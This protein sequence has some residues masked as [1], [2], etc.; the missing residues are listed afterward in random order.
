MMSAMNTSEHLRQ[1]WPEYLIEG[2]ALGTFMVAASLATCVLE[3]PGSPLNHLVDGAVARRCLIGIAMG[4]T[5]IALIYSPWGQRSGAHMNPA[6][7][8]TFLR[9][10]KIAPTDAAF[11]IVAQ[12]VGGALGVFFVAALWPAAMASPQVNFIATVPGPWGAT[13][14]FAA[15]LL[16]SMLLIVAVLRVSGSVAYARYTGLCAGALVAIFISVEAPVSGMS[17]NPARTFASTLPSGAWAQYWIYLLAPLL[18]MQIG[19]LAFAGT[20]GS[21]RVCAKLQHSIRRRCIH[22]GYVPTGVS[23]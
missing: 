15:E 16:I 3:Y 7:T 13:A 18:G 10:G 12:F 14:A 2:W 11:Y 1:R 4:L 19:A 8:L 17:I 21:K 22:C 6:V 9:L 5:A 20:A 23:P